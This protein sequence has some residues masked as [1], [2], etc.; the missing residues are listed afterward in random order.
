MSVESMS[1]ERLRPVIEPVV[2]GA[3]LDLE[4][5]AIEKVGRREK[6]TVI[7]DADGGVGLDAIAEV[8]SALSTALDDH[9]DVSSS[10]Y[11]LEVTSP[12]VDRP[13]TEPRHW[14]RNRDRLVA[15]DLEDGSSV[16]GRILASD[17]ASATLDVNGHSREVAYPTVRRAVVQVEFSKEREEG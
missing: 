5:L 2:A 15:V 9:P 8:S 12:G 16:M 11:V 1:I 14:R 10:P 4:D 17:E 7:V 3:G 13:L 6:V